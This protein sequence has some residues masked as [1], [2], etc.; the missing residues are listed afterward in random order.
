MT[1]WS[2]VYPPES[3]PWEQDWHYPGRGRGPLG[4]FSLCRCRPSAG[5]LWPFLC[6]PPLC[7]PCW[8][9][10]PGSDIFP[11]SMT[12]SWSCGGPRLPVELIRPSAGGSCIQ[13]P[14][15]PASTS[16]PGVKG[17]RASGRAALVRARC[18]PPDCMRLGIGRGT[19]VCSLRPVIA[20]G[21]SLRSSEVQ[22]RRP[23]SPF[24]SGGPDGAHYILF[25]CKTWRSENP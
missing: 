24:T 1:E 20:P 8:T 13:A 7:Q 4:P 18:C 14:R 19:G 12:A 25:G 17:K 9:P 16:P 22:F 11:N 2:P 15:C 3:L 5:Q 21:P 23:L 10:C 6:C